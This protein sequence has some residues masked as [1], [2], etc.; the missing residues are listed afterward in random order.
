MQH[1]SLPMTKFFQ[2]D[3]KIQTCEHTKASYDI[4]KKVFF[5]SYGQFFAVVFFTYVQVCRHIFCVPWECFG[6]CVEVRRVHTHGKS[7]FKTML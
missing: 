2:P 7:T 4:H 5:C 6:M 3:R 1:F